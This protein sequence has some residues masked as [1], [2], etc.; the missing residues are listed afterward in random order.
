MA[1][2]CK[3]WLWL[4]LLEGTNYFRPWGSVS[5]AVKW[6]W[7]EYKP[8]QLPGESAMQLGGTACGGGSYVCRRGSVLPLPTIAS[9]PASPP[10]V[11]NSGLLQEAALI[12]AQTSPLC[13]A[14][15]PSCGLSHESPQHHGTTGTCAI[16]STRSLPLC[17]CKRR[18]GWGVSRTQRDVL[19]PHRAGV[20]WCMLGPVTWHLVG[21]REALAASLATAHQPESPHCGKDPGLLLPGWSSVVIPRDRGIELWPA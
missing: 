19:R 11:E 6:G 5:S 8:W 20:H 9:I 4:L 2:L 14:P 3:I 17:P 12:S 7:L 13:Q 21:S 15:C 10:T 16:V 1:L 18:N